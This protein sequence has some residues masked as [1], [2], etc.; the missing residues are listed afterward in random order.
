M[1]AGFKVHT[2]FNVKSKYIA[3]VNFGLTNNVYGVHIERKDDMV[4]TP[5]LTGF[6]QPKG[7]KQQSNK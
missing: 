5:A 7:I 1:K 4:I 2:R 3:V 6:W